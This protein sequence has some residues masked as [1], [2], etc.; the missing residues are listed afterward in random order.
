MEAFLPPLGH[1]GRSVNNREQTVSDSNSYLSS[2]ILFE[3]DM[4]SYTHAPLAVPDSTRDFVCSMT[5]TVSSD[6]KPLYKFLVELPLYSLRDAIICLLLGEHI[7]LLLVEHE[8]LAIQKEN[9]CAERQYEL[10]ARK[11][12]AQQALMV[13]LHHLVPTP[14]AIL[15]EHIIQL[16]RV[17]GFDGALSNHK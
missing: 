11:R 3:L 13:K 5:D 7:R 15:P 6:G 8:T 4:I 10:A 12:D 2:L 1:R 14:I 17:L 16:I 9:A